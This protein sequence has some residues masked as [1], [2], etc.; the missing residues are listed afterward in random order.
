MTLDLVRSYVHEVASILSLRGRDAAESSLL[1]TM[2]DVCQ[3]P[4]KVL[5][6]AQQVSIRLTLGAS[7][8]RFPDRAR[9]LCEKTGLSPHFFLSQPSLEIVR[10]LGKGRVSNGFEQHVLERCVDAGHVGG[11]VL[12]HARAILA[13]RHRSKLGH[14]GSNHAPTPSSMAVNP[15]PGVRS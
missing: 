1:R 15:L 3:D 7:G 14:A 11:E 5:W 12:A 4:D 2:I 8:S 6:I 13:V 9:H 10:I